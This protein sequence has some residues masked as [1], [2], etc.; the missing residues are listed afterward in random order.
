MQ[1]RPVFRSSWQPRRRPLRRWVGTK[2]SGANVYVRISGV[3]TLAAAVKVR[4]SGAWVDAAAV[5][6]RV[7]GSWVQV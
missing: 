3:W 1:G 2:P 6:V 4:Q 5:Y 7:S